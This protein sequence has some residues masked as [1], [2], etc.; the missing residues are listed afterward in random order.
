[1]VQPVDSLPGPSSRPETLVGSLATRSSLA[2]PGPSSRATPAPAVVD[3]P[4]SPSSSSDISWVT[5]S[6]TEG[7]VS[8]SIN[9]S[10]SRNRADDLSTPVRPTRM[11]LVELVQFSI[12]EIRGNP[13]AM[14]ASLHLGHLV[15]SFNPE[16]TTESVERH[17][18]VSLLQWFSDSITDEVRDRHERRRSP[19]RNRRDDNSSLG[20]PTITVHPALVDVVQFLIQKVRVNPRAMGASPVLGRLVSSFRPETE[21]TTESVNRHI[22]VSLLQ[23]FGESIIEEALAQQEYRDRSA[24][25]RHRPH[26]PAHGAAQTPLL[27]TDPAVRPAPWIYRTE[28]SPNYK[29][30]NMRNTLLENQWNRDHVCRL[31]GYF[32]KLE[33]DTQEAWDTDFGPIHPFLEREFDPTDAGPLREAYDC[34]YPVIHDKQPE[35]DGSRPTQKSNRRAA[36]FLG[37]CF[38]V[39]SLSMFAFA[40][41]CPTFPLAKKEETPN[42]PHYHWWKFMKAAQ[43]QQFFLASFFNFRLGI[44]SLPPLHVISGFFVAR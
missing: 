43:D 34:S 44:L 21:A 22:A 19:S 6:D 12:Q 28:F 3:R 20:R 7:S 5:G 29:Y 35:D 32:L 40:V 18:A 36:L 27:D 33:H 4:V 42:P 37:F 31:N 41:Y 16:T 14:E 8:S 26:P 24:R 10:P 38:L 30:D 13:D 17:L 1:M 9:G 39:L 23:G 15:S 25:H 11:A 2:E